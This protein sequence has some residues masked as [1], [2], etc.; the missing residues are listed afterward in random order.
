[1]ITRGIWNETED[2]N[3]TK[4][5]SEVNLQGTSGVNSDGQSFHPNKGGIEVTALNTF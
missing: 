2:E 1:M 3:T 4:P 5:F